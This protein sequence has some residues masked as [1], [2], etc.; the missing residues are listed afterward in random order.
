MVDVPIWL[1][2][3]IRW[4][5]VKK[6]KI[7]NR[8]KQK[9]SFIKRVDKG[10]IAT[11]KDLESWRFERQPFEGHIFAL[12]SVVLFCTTGLVRKHIWNCMQWPK[13]AMKEYRF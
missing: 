1:M 2:K 8:S 9:L 11:V 4:Y 6:H 13:V 12:K 3:A 5:S 7:A 10:W